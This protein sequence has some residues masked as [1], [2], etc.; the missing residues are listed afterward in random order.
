[1]FLII[2]KDCVELSWLLYFV[3]ELRLIFFWWFCIFFRI[4]KII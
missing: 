2:H 1:M 4:S 3:D